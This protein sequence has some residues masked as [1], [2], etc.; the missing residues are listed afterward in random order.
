MSA[1][2]LPA[3]KRQTPLPLVK[4]DLPA[5]PAPNTS[6][7][8]RRHTKGPAPRGPG[9]RVVPG[10]QQAIAIASADEACEILSRSQLSIEQAE[11]VSNAAYQAASFANV[12]ITA[13]RLGL[14][15]DFSQITRAE[16]KL[17]AFRILRTGR[18]VRVAS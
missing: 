18:R 3:V 2:T 1:A 11:R 12:P 17:L 7:S 4:K 6:V 13:E 14:L 16:A 5:T 15:I 9:R 10:S 8:P